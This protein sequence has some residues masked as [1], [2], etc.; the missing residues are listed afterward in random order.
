MSTL[1]KLA[2]FTAGFG[3][4]AVVAGAST[5]HAQVQ[6]GPRQQPG[7]RVQN[8]PQA[9]QKSAGSA[10]PPAPSGV[11]NRTL[12]AQAK[13][14]AAQ[15][16][17]DAK[18]AQA[19]S[20]ARRAEA[21]AKAREAEATAKSREAEEGRKAQEAAAA[22]TAEK[23]K[24]AASERQSYLGPAAQ[25]AAGALGALAAW[26]LGGALGAKA[27]DA[28]KATVKAV[29]A[30]GKD[31][32][33]LAKTKSLVAGTPAGDKMKAIVQEANAL[34]RSS[35]FAS[36]GKPGKAADVVA[37]G[38]TIEGTVSMGASMVTDDPA[39]KQAL[40]IAAA[41]SLGGAIGL[42]SALSV[43][44]SAAPRPSSRAISSINAGANRL[45]REGSG[46]AATVSRNRVQGEVA[47]STGKLKATKS[48]SRVTASRAE[49]KAVEAAGTVKRTRAR[50]AK[51][52]KNTGKVK[53]YSRT[54]RSGRKA[55]T[56]ETV[57]L[58]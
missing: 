30:L 56:T 10:S 50:V 11:S 18:R 52:V 54:Y 2:T 58:N 45:A 25:I 42:K 19:E 4:G 51:S 41:A 22:A 6:P 55:G 14:Q 28:A 35:N 29:N 23:E 33:A 34:G 47:K 13:A 32:G 40:R 48:E 3:A 8:I 37:A 12:Q 17:A 21:D 5:G 26:K 24:R 44:R 39:T 31:A 53:Q 27:A 57:T 43:A 38:L 9:P 7:P 46:G 36:L 1:L 49:R 16:E 15:A 20:E